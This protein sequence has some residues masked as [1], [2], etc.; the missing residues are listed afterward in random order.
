MFIRR[1]RLNHLKNPLGFLL[2]STVF[3]WVVDDTDATCAQASRIVV[4]GADG[5][6][7]DTGWAQLDSL[8]TKL[9]LRLAPRTRYEWTVSVRTETG[10]EATSQPAWFETGKQD[11]PWSAQWLSCDGSSSTRHPLFSTCLSLTGEVAS[12]RLY[13]CGLGFYDAQLDGVRIGDE[14]L[15]PGTNAYDQWLQVQTY[16]V[17]EQLRNA[18]PKPTLSFLMGNGW[19]KGRFGF[20]PEDRGFYGS[21]WRLIAELHVTYADGS[22][23]VFATGEGWQMGRSNITASNIY[24]GMQVDDTLP[25]AELVPAPL[26]ASDDAAEATAKL[27]DRLSLPVTAHETFTPSV[28]RVPS[29]NLVLDLGQEFAGT[30]RLRVHE[31]AGTTV[32]VQLGELLQD[33]EFYNENLR[34]A[35]QEYVYVSDGF[36]HVLEPRFTYYGYRYA[37]IEGLSSFDATDFTGV[38]LYSDF[39]E[40]GTL[41]TGHALV[42]KLVSNTRWGMKSNFVDTPTDCPQRDERMGW[43]GDAQ[44][45]APTALYLADQLPFYRKFAYDMAREADKFGGAA[46]LV[47][48]AFMLEGPACAVWG[49]ATC[50]I[51]WQSYLFSGDASV[52]EEH[53]DAM[54]AWVDHIEREDGGDK[55]LWG[56]LHQLGDWLALDAPKNDR[57]GATDPDFIA[58]LY[59]W[60]SACEVADAARVLGRE[61]DATRYDAMAERVAAYIDAEYFT[62]NGRCAVTTQTA[63]ALCIA[64]GFGS[65]TFSAFALDRAL[66][67][68]EGK[69][70]TGFVGT[71]FLPRALCEAGMASKAYDLLLNEGYP[72][73]LREIKLGA[74]TIWERWNSL[75]DDGVITGIGMNS[76][77][78]Y[79]YGSIVEWLFAYAAGLRPVASEP[80]FR[81]AIVA[82]LPA[83][84]L[85][86]LACE[87][88]T[89][90]GTWR[91]AWAC[92][93]ERHLRF[94]LTVPFGCTAEV[95]LPLA[96]E[97]AYVALGGH[98]LAAGTYAL[99]YETS[100]PLRRVPSIDWPIGDLLAAPD[101]DAVVRAHCKPDWIA[102]DEAHLSLRELAYKLARGS[103]PMSEEALAACDAQLRALAE[104]GPVA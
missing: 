55:H 11:E 36:E 96:D 93:D 92:V 32:R 45:F 77:N 28:V 52:L 33:G 62:P 51:P 5:I 10:E 42:N 67:R 18:G 31:P 79:S 14:Y 91:V 38:A 9:E 103:R 19:W 81:R 3:S 70:V 47:A 44:V 56:G 20:I 75:D 102:P 99:T 71:N 74:T 34:S 60:R 30:F 76:M 24:D 49:D 61:Q 54:S 58:Y 1:L 98:E 35:K 59:W 83:W 6:V 72:G 17:T 65:P 39:E 26:L 25:V 101:T 37:R 15:A 95:T 78:H 13:A 90:A 85:G 104:Q 46:P 57:T 100:A 89:S 23:Q 53:F 41:T 82:P 73:W 27:T 7:A 12:A 97:S 68:N 86:H 87:R 2:T 80:G 64:F 84:R 66:A 29:G 69:L 63:Y 21:D 94:E 16:D 48:P 8:A 22:E 4:T 50:F 88:T 43:T 40:V